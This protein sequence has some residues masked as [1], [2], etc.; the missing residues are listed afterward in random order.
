LPDTRHLSFNKWDDLSKI[1]SRTA[2]VVVEPIQA[3][4]GIVEPETDY[5]KAL[6]E[7]CRKT[8]ALLVFDEVQTGFGRTG[9]LFAF[10][11]FDVV[12][13]IL[14]LGKALGGGMPVA[15][16][17][18]SG[19]IMSALK[20]NP[21]LGHITTFG[22][23]PLCCAAAVASLQT[24]LNGNILNQVQ[25]KGDIFYNRLIQHP[26]VLGMT[27]RG[28]FRSV[29]LKSRIQVKKILPVLLREGILSNSFIF[30][31]DRFRIAPPLVI[32]HEEIDLA[33]EKIWLALDE[34][35]AGGT[36]NLVNS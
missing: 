18:S 23:H 4:A 21:V 5:L 27:G 7:R 12:P 32:T 17:V 10:E 1:T 8:G 29:Q 30:L 16:F 24:L 6:Q 9:T 36:A 28:L 22:G 14:V 33:L 15:A 19:Q 2:C 11:Q 31:F 13:D 20:K 35:H 3:E 26:E 25:N 34:I